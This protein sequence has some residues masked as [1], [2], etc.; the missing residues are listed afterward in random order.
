MGKFLYDPDCIKQMQFVNAP[1]W[2]AAGY[3]GK[4]QT[5][6]LDD[7]VSDPGHIAT[8]KDI[9]QSLLP[10]IR[11][12][13]GRINFATKSGEINIVTVK[14]IETGELLPFDDFVNKYGVGLI[15]NSTDGGNG[16]EVQPHALWMRDKIKQHNLIVTGAAGNGNG[17]PTTQRFNGACIM[18]TSCTLK[19]G[20]PVFAN[21]ACGPNLDFAIFSGY[22][23]GTSHSAPFLL[24]LAGLLRSK[25]PG[26]TQDEVYQYLKDHCVDLGDKNK[27][28][29]GVPVMGAAK[30]V[31]KM[32]PGKDVMT[33]DGREVKLDEP[34]E[35]KPSGR[36]VVPVRA[37]S[38]A[39]GAD[40]KWDPA[41]KTITI[42][43]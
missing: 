33:V 34:P 26:I 12:L 1:A 42:V 19:N 16:T 4:G 39:F 40:V 5:V 13:S 31:I 36:T 21:K 6:F 3:T 15:N 41:S 22:Q 25:W 27:F 17:Q 30:T 11:V 20:R 29:W 24:A 9:I 35:I 8:S 14:C 7:V 23:S 43:R 32:W 2:I 37:I 28:G 38:E 10:D 18:V